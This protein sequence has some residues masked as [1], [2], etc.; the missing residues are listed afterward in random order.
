[1]MHNHGKAVFHFKCKRLCVCL[2]AG[3][4][5]FCYMGQ[6][7]WA[8]AGIYNWGIARYESF[9]MGWSW[10]D[11]IFNAAYSAYVSI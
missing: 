6:S 11:L 9:S 10:N 5:S 4:A 3:A 1:M 7:R 2:K 8:S